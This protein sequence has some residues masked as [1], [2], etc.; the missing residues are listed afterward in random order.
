[1][2]K[3]TLVIMAAGMGSR[4]GGLKQLT[5]VDPEGHI[6]MDFSIYDAI[7]AGFGKVVFVLSPEMQEGFENLVGSKICKKIQLEYAIQSP[8]KIPDGFTIPEGRVKPWGTA[9]AVLCAAPYID[10]P[11]AVINADDFY[12]WEAFKAIGQFLT[13]PHAPNEHAMVGY[14]V[15]NTLTEN[16]SV[17]R[18]V[19]EVS[20]KDY[21]TGITERTRIEGRPDGAAFTE[22]GITY[23]HLDSDTV[24]SMNLWGFQPEILNAFK[25][26]FFD[27]LTNIVPNNPMKSEFFLPVIPSDMISNGT[28]TVKVL[29]T[30]SRWYGVTYKADLPGVINAIAEMKEM[31]QY[32]KYLWE[33]R[34]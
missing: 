13:E 29:H 30:K 6:I 21:L 34:I 23:V 12:G 22:D 14:R 33:D 1:M 3:P 24:V 28:G 26:H 7:R 17:S 11:F 10:G 5:P 20:P 15:S 18:G 32:P 25:K 27:F 16:G 31:G 8:D 19:C 4:F 2:K 9:H